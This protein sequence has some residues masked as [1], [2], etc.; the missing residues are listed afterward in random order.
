[1]QTV[2]HSLPGSTRRIHPFTRHV[3]HAFVSRNATCRILP[4]LTHLTSL[5]TDIYLKHVSNASPPI[6]H[7]ICFVQWDRQGD[8][9]LQASRDGLEGRVRRYLAAGVDAGYEDSEGWTALHEASC[10]KQ[11]LGVLLILL[12]SANIDV[13]KRNQDK[14]TPLIL[15]AQNGNYYAVVHLLQYNAKIN[16][17]HRWGYNALDYASQNRYRHIVRALREDGAR[18]SD[19]L[20]K[21]KSSLVRAMVHMDTPETMLRRVLE[22]P[23]VRITFNQL[24]NVLNVSRITSALQF[25]SANFL[26]QL[27]KTARH[28]LMVWF[29][30]FDESRDYLQENVYLQAAYIRLNKGEQFMAQLVAQRAEDCKLI[31][32]ES[33]VIVRHSIRFGSELRSYADKLQEVRDE[34][35]K[36]YLNLRNRMCRVEEMSSKVREILYE[37]VDDD[38]QMAQTVTALCD[39]FNK[40]SW[41][42]EKKER[43]EKYAGVFRFCL[44][45]IPIVG[46]SLALSC[47]SADLF[48]GLPAENVFGVATDLAKGV[49][50][51]LCGVDLSDSISV[52]AVTSRAFMSNIPRK[53]RKQI[54]FAAQQS[55]FGCLRNVSKEL[56]LV[57]H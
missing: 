30:D 11:S 55:E 20:G 25:F 18:K 5:P 49:V 12:K 45:F 53:S 32:P 4:S 8:K 36:E 13:N 51:L 28:P 56:D 44:S 42:L 9:L 21:R 43:L 57:D 50:S 2:N 1:M 33:A 35:L 22:E 37:L 7:I 3:L 54:E 47:A 41:A 52:G 23:T 31:R 26:A 34:L 48:A 16:R 24:A 40:L 27:L 39:S 15:A 19:N 6:V 38:Q 14:E 29:S 46:P 17:Q 10:R